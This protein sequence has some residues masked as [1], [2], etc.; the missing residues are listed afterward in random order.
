MNKLAF[1]SVFLAL[2]LALPAQ[3]AT[4]PAPEPA[5]APTTITVNDTPASEELAQLVKDQAAD[6]AAFDTKVQQANF[7][8]DQNTKALKNQIT[9]AQKDLN[10]K[11]TADK[12]YKPLLDNI[13][14]LQKQLT[15]NGSKI[16]ADFNKE[17]GPLQ[18]KLN[19]EANEIQGLIP[20]VKKENNLPDNATF[21]PVTGKWSVPEKK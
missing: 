6:K 10:D 19:L 5:E 11:L 15:D 12:K 16:Q 20:V 4:K 18:Q 8:Y 21:D 7:T 9:A 2:P 13:T 17:A 14:N 3:A 1:L